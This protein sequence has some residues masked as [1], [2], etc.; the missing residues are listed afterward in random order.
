MDL[1]GLSLNKGDIITLGLR[2]RDGSGRTR[3]QMI[4]MGYVKE[5]DGS[6]I[7]G[8]VKED[9]PYAPVEEAWQKLQDKT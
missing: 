3:T 4:W 1:S 5:N 6:L 8:V 7:G 2:V 9:K